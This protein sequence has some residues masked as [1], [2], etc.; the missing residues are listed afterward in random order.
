MSN[1]IIYGLSNA[2][3]WPILS[4]SDAGVPTYGSIIS[5]PGATAMSLDAEGS[6][7]PFYA[8]NIV[9]Y[10]PV[11]NNG[12]SGSITLADIPDEFMTTVMGDTTDANGVRIENASAQP[13]EFAIAFEFEGDE[14]KRR[15]V[16]WRCKAT[17]PQIASSTKEDSIT[18]NTQELS[19][20]AMPRLDNKN[21]KA[22]C[23]YGDAGY[24]S[25]YGTAPYASEAYVPTYR[26]TAV[27]PA[28]TE[29]PAS[30]GW[31]E[32][33][34]TVGSYTYTLTA[35]TTVDSETTYYIRTVAE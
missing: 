9:Y 19:F 7:D 28:G 21:V 4:V 27:A 25:W 10:Q 16:F 26:Y 17:R 18:P 35:D 11:S 5:M 31:Y 23:E 12:Y 8:D 6:S 30:E 24:D 14:K 33:S 15:H 3:I 2:H 29:N 32:R 34:G 20:S 13:K 22:S 1:K